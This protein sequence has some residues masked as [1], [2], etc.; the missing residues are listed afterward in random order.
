MKKILLII[1]ILSL[2]VIAGCNIPQTLD[3][4]Y[5]SP[6]PSDGPFDSP[7]TVKIT[8]PTADARIYYTLDGSEP[9]EEDIMLYTKPIVI[10]KSTLIKAISYKDDVLLSSQ[11]ING[12]FI[13]ND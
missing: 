4:P 8:S 1:G 13:I 10:K 3:D 2:I 12:R 6:K 7:I 9:E 11:I 5:F